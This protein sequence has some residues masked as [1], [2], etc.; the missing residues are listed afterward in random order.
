MAPL[1][2]LM[3]ALFSTSFSAGKVLL[4]YTTPLMLCGIRM[5]IAGVI[6]VAYQY[7]FLKKRTPITREHI[8]VYLQIIVLGIYVAYILRFWGLKYL[9]SSKTA[10]LFNASP[11]FAALFSYWFFKERMTFKQWIGLI[12]GFLGLIPILITT[13]ST[14]QS[15]GEFLFISWPE[16][17]ILVCVGLHSYS[18]ILVR[19]ALRFKNHTPILVNGITMLGGGLLALATAYLWE[20]FQPISDP[21]PFTAWLFFVIL[22]SNIICYNLYGYLLKRYSAT[23]ISFAGFLVPIFAALF[24]WGLLHETITWHFYASSMIVFVG[25][26]LFYQDELKRTATYP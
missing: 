10:L 14:E 7:L 21:V 19:K 18:W 4:T 1:I 20:G 3:Y 11:F 23:F 12:I 17:A 24:G 15:L 8:G 22:V 26:Y 16:L 2:I 6:L 5:S 25:L 9:P 13:S